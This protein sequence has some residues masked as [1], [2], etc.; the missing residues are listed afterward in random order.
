MPAALEL[1]Y[2]PKITTSFTF[3]PVQTEYVR[4]FGW[5]FQHERL[6]DAS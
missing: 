2:L 3:F 5:H 4:L 1:S 6:T